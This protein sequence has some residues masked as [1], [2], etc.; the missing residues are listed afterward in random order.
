MKGA[1]SKRQ[2]GVALLTALLIV[3]L[4]TIIATSA[5]WDFNIDQRRTA[6][7]LNTDQA[8]MYALGAEAWASR[9][10]IEDAEDSSNDHPGESWSTDLPPLPIDGGTVAGAIID[11]QGRFNINN[12]VDNDGQT[13]E[14]TVEQFERMLDILQLERSW[15]RM[16]ADWIDADIDPNFPSGAE[17]SVY[18]GMTPPRRTPNVPITSITELMALPEMNKEAFDVLAPHI[19]ALP[20]GTAINVNTATPVVLQSLSQDLS[21][22]DAE[23]IIADRPADGYESTAELSS[24]IPP[25]QLTGLSVSSEYFRTAIRVNVGS[26]DLTMYSL[27]EREGANTIRTLLRSYGT[28]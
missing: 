22:S 5:M 4:A 10:L 7:M 11:L 9:I 27:L 26:V 20:R 1:E 12:L 8:V 6:M 21:Q 19:T 25:E 24:S 15:A 28:E 13:D 16:A 3:A 2:A 17:D 23:S 14:V 18:M